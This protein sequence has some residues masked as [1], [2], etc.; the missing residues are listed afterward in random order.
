[1]V[2]DFPQDRAGRNPTT[3]YYGVEHLQNIKTNNNMIDIWR[4]QHPT[5]KEYAY[6]NNL[7]DFKLRID[8][9]YLT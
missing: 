6:I 2:E 5:K 8:K 4:K 9:F 7:A 1:M 3:Q